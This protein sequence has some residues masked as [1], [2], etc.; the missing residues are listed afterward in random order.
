MEAALS[1]DG[2]KL[3]DASSVDGSSPMYVVSIHSR[4]RSKDQGSGNRLHLYKIKR[5][6]KSKGLEKRGI[7]GLFYCF[8]CCY[9][10][11]SCNGFSCLGGLLVGRRN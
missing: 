3:C 9:Q 2:W 5:K 10:P 11:C 6:E 4:V 1:M 8:L 7:G